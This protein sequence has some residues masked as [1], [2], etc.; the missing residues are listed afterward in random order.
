MIDK[1]KIRIFNNGQS[2]AYQTKYYKYVLSSWVNYENEIQVDIIIT[3]LNS[4]TEKMFDN[5]NKNKIPKKHINILKEIIE[6]YESTII[7]FRVIDEGYTY[8]NVFEDLFN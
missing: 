6:Y 5:F 1:N 8:I 4:L 3:Y 2:L 7:M